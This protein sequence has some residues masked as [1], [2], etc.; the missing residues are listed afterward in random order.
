MDR[1]PIVRRDDLDSTTGEDWQW[2]P[3][4][5]G[6]T[7]AEFAEVVSGLEPGDRVIAHSE[8]LPETDLTLRLPRSR[9]ILH[10]RQRLQ[11]V[12]GTGRA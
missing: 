1:R 4:A 7:D 11:L 12:D 6:V 5:L 9:S 10:W 8:T 2:R 3:I